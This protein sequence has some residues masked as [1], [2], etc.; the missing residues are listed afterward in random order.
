MALCTM[1][2][3]DLFETILRP[4]YLHR[5]SCDP[6]DIQ[7]FKPQDN[8]QQY[9]L[10]CFFGQQQTINFLYLRGVSYSKKS[11][12]FSLLNI[13]W[14]NDIKFAD[15]LLQ[16]DT[17]IICLQQ[18]PSDNEAYDLYKRL[19][20]HY[21]HFYI[22]LGEKS[23]FIASKFALTSPN[24]SCNIFDFVVKNNNTLISHIYT[25]NKAAN[26]SQVIAKMQ[27]DC[28]NSENDMTFFLGCETD[29]IESFQNY[30]CY[31]KSLQSSHILILQPPT[32][33]EMPEVTTIC[34]DNFALL[35]TVSFLQKIPIALCGWH[36]EVD[37]SSK[38]DTKGHSEASAS[39]EVDYEHKCDNG[40]TIS[41]GVEAT[42]KVD[43][44]GNCS[45]EVQTKIRVDF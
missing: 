12:T 6:N 11:T 8:Y 28:I 33:C 26:M 27:S 34:N 29:N 22:S 38:S 42:G 9:V 1:E 13:H 23:F 25:A 2:A 30:F 15:T 10:N 43:N 44:Q 5:G 20:N 36:G 16:E 7:N 21:A 24:F 35:T 17:D 41:A 18:L 39:A 19:K 14:N 4:W 3:N 32:D 31:A 40:T 37:V 45:G